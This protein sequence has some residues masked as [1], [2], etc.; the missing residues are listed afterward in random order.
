MKMDKDLLT[1]ESKTELRKGDF[2]VDEKTN[3][4]FILKGRDYYISAGIKY[5]TSYYT[6][7]ASMKFGKPESISVTNE[8]YPTYSPLRYATLPEIDD[9]LFVLK[10]NGYTWNNKTKELI[11]E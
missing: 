5:Y 10:K 1:P 3:E 8:K 7:W 6:S 2:I 11:K 4:V 9:F